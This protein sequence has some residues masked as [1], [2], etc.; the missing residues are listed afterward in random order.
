MKAALLVFVGGGLGSVL[1]WLTVLAA[2]RFWP[3]GGA[4]RGVWMANVLGSLLL[5]FL[6]AWPALRGRSDGAWLFL[7]TGML[8]G[9]TTFSTLA[10]DSWRLMLE[11]QPALALLNAAGSLICGIGAAALGWKLAQGLLGPA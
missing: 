10:Q 8:G 1:R 9:F 11:Q 4:L 6:A 2:Q 5:G 3:Q 7:A